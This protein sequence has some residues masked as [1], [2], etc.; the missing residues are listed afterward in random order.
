MGNHGVAC[1]SYCYSGPACRDIVVLS[2]H[3][4]VTV[5]V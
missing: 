5:S 2:E 3:E 1:W 4:W